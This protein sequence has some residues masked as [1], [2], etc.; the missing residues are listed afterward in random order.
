M[1][2][3][4]RHAVRP[5]HEPVAEHE[6]TTDAGADR[7]GDQVAHIASRT[8][9]ELAPRGGVGVVLDDRR[10]TAAC[11]H[12][13]AERLLDPRQVGCRE[14][15]LTGRIHVAGRAQTDP[16]RSAKTLAVGDRDQLV[17]DLDDGLDD[18]LG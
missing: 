5:A 4:S 2:E 18:P 1:T 13:G 16:Y 3:L 7:D 10:E 15:D 6:S 12:C 9:A 17:D 14:D 11:R 8:E